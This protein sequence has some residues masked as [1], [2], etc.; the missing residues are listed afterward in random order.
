MLATNLHY[1]SQERYLFEEVLINGKLELIK[2]NIQDYKDH[3]EHKQLILEMSEGIEDSKQAQELKAELEK[4]LNATVKVIKHTAGDQNTEEHYHFQ[5]LTNTKLNN[6]SIYK[7][8]ND[9]I[10]AEGAN[11][12]QVRIYDNSQKNSFHL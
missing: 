5:I 10:R 3:E 1:N 6:Q 11:M 7:I 2:I 12:T 4:K 9:F 8:A